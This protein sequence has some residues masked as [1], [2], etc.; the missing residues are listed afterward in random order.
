LI[1][2][3]M[4]MGERNLGLWVDA[5][6]EEREERGVDLLLLGLQGEGE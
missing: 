1:N 2:M 6:R 5:E 4:S 3:K